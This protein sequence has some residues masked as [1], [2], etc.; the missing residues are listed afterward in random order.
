MERRSIELNAGLHGNAP[1]WQSARAIHPDAATLSPATT[2][3]AYPQNTAQ[4]VDFVI[5]S[6]SPQVFTSSVDGG[7]S[8]SRGIGW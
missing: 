4:H 8:A 7:H 3:F 6:P 1:L 5:Y 2:N